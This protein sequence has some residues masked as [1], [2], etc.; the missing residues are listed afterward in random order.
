TG[1]ILDVTSGG[2]HAP[3][4]FHQSYCKVGGRSRRAQQDGKRYIVGLLSAGGGGVQAALNSTFVDGLREWG[5]FEGE[6]VVFENRKAE[7]R[8]ERLFEATFET[9]G[10]VRPHALISVASPLTARCRNGI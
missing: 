1:V 4:R 3:T 5:W 7:D 10:R 8:L 2:L 6:N 9:A